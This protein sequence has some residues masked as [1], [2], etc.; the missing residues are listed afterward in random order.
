MVHDIN[1]FFFFSRTLLVN[2]LMII[3][4][5]IVIIIIIIIIIIV[6]I[7]IIT[8]L[9]LDKRDMIN[10]HLETW[11]FVTSFIHRYLAKLVKLCR[12]HQT[13]TLKSL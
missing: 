1:M 5:I 6:I 13:R 8:T 10:D 9:L 11:C 7:I 12:S 2:Y 4:I 3:I